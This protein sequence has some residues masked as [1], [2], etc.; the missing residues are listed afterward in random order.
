MKGCKGKCN[1]I[2]GAV[3]NLDRATYKLGTTGI[4]CRNCEVIFPI[5][6]PLIRIDH[7]GGK[8]CPCCNLKISNRIR[9]KKAYREQLE[10]AKVIIRY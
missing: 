7:L 3:T 2:S 6:H 4:Q 1:N 10:L 9:N 5:N 8:H